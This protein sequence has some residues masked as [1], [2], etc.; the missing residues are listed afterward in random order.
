M[1]RV[2][3]AALLTLA[4]P[5]GLR[6][7]ELAV[8]AAASLADAL[9]EL[10]RAYEASSGRSVV[11]NFGASSDLARQIQAGAAADLF[12]SADRAQV[13]ALEAAGLVR[14]KD[15]ADVLSNVLVV[16]TPA[17]S[18]AALRSAAELLA[19][20]RIAMADPDAVPA[21]VY[22]R[23][24]LQSAGLWTRLRQRVVPTLNVRAALA[25]V[26]S[27]NADAGIVYRTDAM[28]APGTRVAFAVAREDGPTIVYVLARLAA[29][30]KP[31]AGDLSRFLASPG[32]AAVYE[33][34]GFIVLAGR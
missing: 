6:G 28:V 26:A 5:G 3:L 22:G 19:V 34:H 30:K 20:R 2:A 25:A 8:F 14:G 27:G 7:E 32:A 4:P 18:R 12:F 9:E 16:V 11:L 1:F 31:G 10:A 13:D 17:D 24:W 21:G 29:S 23:A 15:R 33:R